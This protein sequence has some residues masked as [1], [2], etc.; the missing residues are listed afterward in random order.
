MPT[1]VSRLTTAILVLLGAAFG[2]AIAPAQNAAPTAENIAS[3]RASA[4]TEETLQRFVSECVPIT[5]GEGNFPKT[6]SVGTKSPAAHE[7]PLQ[8]T[9]ITAG[10]R[11]SKY[12]TTQELYTAVMGKNPSRWKG[13]RN[14]VE[15]VSFDDTGRFCQKLTAI[16]RNRELIRKKD[17]VRLPTSVEWEYCC[18]AGSTTRYF[19]GQKP[20][21]HQ[22]TKALDTFAWHTGNA[23]GND[24]AVGVLK[25]NAWGLYDTH[26]YL[27]EFVTHSNLQP[28]NTNQGRCMVR[29]GSWKDQHP[30]L[31]SSTY[32]MM[33]LEAK[34]D[35]V[36]FRCVIAEEPIAKK[37]SQR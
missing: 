36:G 11:I 27:W 12:E 17:I 37:T 1:N 16:L 9:A 33:S 23:A 15:N 24:P 2:T 14:S 13:P 28:A 21:S 20:G 30:R 6:F 4:D 34:D 8:E 29:S 18:R 19:F 26:G 25:P 10:F 31:S 7:L 5:P 3:A 32:L 22:T 35:A